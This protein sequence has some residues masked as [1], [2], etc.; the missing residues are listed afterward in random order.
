VTNSDELFPFIF[1]PWS[2]GQSD[3]E[4]LAIVKQNADKFL[5]MVNPCLIYPID[6]NVSLDFNIS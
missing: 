2:E 1:P 5:D 3:E 4:Y 6:A